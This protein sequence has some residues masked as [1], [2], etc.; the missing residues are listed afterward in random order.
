[1]PGQPSLPVGQRAIEDTGEPSILKGNERFQNQHIDIGIPL[2]LQ[3]D[4]LR[5]F[6][7]DLGDSVQQF[8]A[9]WP[10]DKGQPPSIRVLI[11]R[12]PGESHYNDDNDD[13]E[14]DKN[15]TSSSFRQE[16]ANATHLGP[17]PILVRPQGSSHLR[18]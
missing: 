12:F 10:S 15:E 9:E 16:L 6:C 8:Y 17:D 18:R 14:K 5:T 7:R 2:Y 3:D 11:T 13:E 1:M 4:R